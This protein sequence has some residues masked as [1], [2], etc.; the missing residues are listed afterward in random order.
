MLIY[1]HF[2]YA[3][4]VVAA[5]AEAVNS[6]KRQFRSPASSW[7]LSNWFCR[8]AHVKGRA[9]NLF[10]KYGNFSGLDPALPLFMSGDS[11]THLSAGDAKFVGT[12]LHPVRLCWCIH[13]PRFV[14]RRHSHRR[15]ISGNPVGARPRRLL[16]QWWNRSPAGLRARRV[17]EKQFS[18]HRRWVALDT[19]PF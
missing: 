19:F 7:L 17:V 11:N 9:G 8:S 13:C 14:F 18:R 10:R 6:R 16:P 12:A 2:T 4:R 15:R 5:V 1:K 3:S